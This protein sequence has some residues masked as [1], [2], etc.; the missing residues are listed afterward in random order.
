MQVCLQILMC[1]ML[2][3]THLLKIIFKFRSLLFKIERKYAYCFFKDSL[4][5][6]WLSFIENIKFW[7]STDCVHMS[8]LPIQNKGKMLLMYSYNCTK[9]C[10]KIINQNRTEF[11]Y[12]KVI[13]IGPNFTM[14]LLME[15]LCQIYLRV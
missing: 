9:V 15:Y 6:G 1:W 13:L 2:P 5:V 14:L 10:E 7:F 8:S 11:F 3:T 4:V 12:L